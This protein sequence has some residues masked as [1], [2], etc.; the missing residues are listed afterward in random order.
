MILGVGVDVVDLERFGAVLARQPSIVDR[1][2]TTGE[3]AYAELGQDPVERYAARFAAKEATLKA[4]GVGIGTVGWH[5]I[6]VVRSESGRPSVLLRGAAAERARQVGI[7]RVDVA[8][9]H[10]DLVAEAV[11]IAQ[12]G[13]AP[14]DEGVD[15]DGAERRLDLVEL[16]IAEGLVPIV[17][18]A[19][20]GVI[21]AEAPEPVD[22][23]IARAGSA[24]ARAAVEMMGGTYGRRVVVLEGKGNNGND[25]R[26]AARRLR[27]AWCARP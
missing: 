20:M 18:P 24:V 23:L 13:A 11:V 9:T 2:F 7:S 14:R 22:V 10:S 16:P 12:G 15:V 6:E 26:E 1:L 3:R 8:L 19:E 21:D 4:L 17:T 25:G 5:D 27:R